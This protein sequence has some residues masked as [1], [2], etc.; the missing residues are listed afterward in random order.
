MKLA[1]FFLGKKLQVF[2]SFD[3]LLSG[4]SVRQVLN[5]FLSI[6]G[7]LFSFSVLVSSFCRFCLSG[8]VLLGGICVYISSLFLCYQI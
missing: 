6:F 2:G 5:V 8:R 4:E 1:L 3:T 7:K